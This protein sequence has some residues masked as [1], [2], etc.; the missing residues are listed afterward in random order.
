MK[1][2][3]PRVVAAAALALA[4]AAAKLALL[5]W[6]LAPAQGQAN[7]AVRTGRALFVG[8]QPLSA[9][10]SSQTQPLPVQAS[11]CVNCHSAPGVRPAAGAGPA[12]TAASGPPAGFGPALHSAALMQL[13]PRRGGPPSRYDAPAL[14]RTLRE[15]IDPAGVM[16]A[17]AMPRYT[18]NEA[19][20]RALWTLLTSDL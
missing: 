6:V 3:S 11:R 1:A 9:R 8:E 16:L 5:A 13:R 15:G 2:V 4:G 18:L 19:Q 10:L 20:C 7:E 14:C 12:A 17:L